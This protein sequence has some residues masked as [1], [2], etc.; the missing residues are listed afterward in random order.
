MEAKLQWR[1][2]FN[3]LVTPGK[4]DAIGGCNMNFADC[5]QRGYTRQPAITN[6]ELT[7]FF[8]MSRQLLAMVSICVVLGTITAIP[9]GG[10]CCQEA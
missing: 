7:G 1:I 10:V 4:K 5:I 2:K 3:I 8:N 6:V 9:I